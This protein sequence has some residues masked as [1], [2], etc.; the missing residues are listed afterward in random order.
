MGSGPQLQIAFFAHATP[1]CYISNF[2]PQKLGPPWQNP[3][4]APGSYS[5]YYIQKHT[6]L[7]SSA[8]K[9]QQSNIFTGICQS[10]C[11][12][13]CL[14]RCMLGYTFWEGTPLWAGTPPGRYTPTPPGRY[15]PPVGTPP[16][17]TVTAVDGTHPTGIF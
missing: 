7:L 12:G 8:T 3:G 11:S 13:G 5:I 1:L 2:Q 6:K 9:L 15:N 17:T 10:F 14:P 16:P 4:S